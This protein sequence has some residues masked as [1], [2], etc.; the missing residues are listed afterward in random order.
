L[1]LGVTSN[2][3]RRIWEHK[4]DLADGFT[5]EY[6]VHTLVWYEVH[7]TMESPISG[8]KVVKGWRRSWK[9][10]LI[11]KSNTQWRDLYEEIV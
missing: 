7:D 11:E 9:L 10:G 5:K 8:E 3:A 4:N 2:L 1:Y 6:Q